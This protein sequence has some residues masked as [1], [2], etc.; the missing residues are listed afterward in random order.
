LLDQSAANECD[1]VMVLQIDPFKVRPP[2]IPGF[3]L[4][5]NR[6]VS[7]PVTLFGLHLSASPRGYN[8]ALY[9]RSKKI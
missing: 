5:Q 4:T 1:A 3:D 6:F 7:A 2:A 8:Y 9:L